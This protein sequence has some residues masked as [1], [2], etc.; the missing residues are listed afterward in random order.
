VRCPPFA[1]YVER[2]VRFYRDKKAE[3][4]RSAMI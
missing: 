1:S 4:R 3:V 2:L